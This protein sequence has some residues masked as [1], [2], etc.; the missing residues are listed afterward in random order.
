MDER[1]TPRPLARWYMPAAIVSLLFMVLG[2][3]ALAMHVTADPATLPLDQRA[4]FE[5]EPRW[6]LAASAAGFL[7]GLIGGLLLVLR[8][9]AAVPLL[10]VSLL[11]VLVWCAGMFVTPEFR[12]LL[13]TDE[14]AG[15]VVV[16]ALTWTIFWFARHSRQ[17]GWLR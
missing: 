2:C 4:L 5:A 1:F 12:D 3:A 11:G 17:R 13:S 14:I 8:R 6:V 10:L 15:L 9:K 16:V 7:A